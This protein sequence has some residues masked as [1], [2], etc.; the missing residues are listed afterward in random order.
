MLT[1]KLLFIL[2]PNAGV[3]HA[4][5]MIPE[6]LELFA[7]Q[8]YLSTVCCTRRRG[9][10]T[11]FARDH[12]AGMN[13]I[14]VSGGDGTLNEVVTGL[15]QGHHRIPV[16]YLPSGST[17]DFAAGLK[18]PGDL[19]KAARI[20]VA[21]KPQ[22]LDVGRFGDRYFCYTAGFGAFTGVAWSTPQNIKNVLGH[23]AYILEGIRSLGE[24]RPIHARVTADG[25]V[26]EDDWIFGAV[27]N[28]TSLGGVLKLDPDTVDMNDGMFE[29]VLIR[30]PSS[31]GE[32]AGI[33]EAVTT[34]NY[35]HPML[36]F[37]RASR[38]TFRTDTSLSWTLDGEYASGEPE[39]VIENIRDAVTV[40][41]PSEPS[42][43]YDIP[44]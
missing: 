20:A 23:A 38:L 25:L 17:N 26:C 31:A 42:F 8:G 1:K 6:L 35:S 40:M 3:R 34:R 43:L 10:A 21:G 41:T 13:L 4:R 16:G 7:D 2:N 30:N 36:H 27:C 33:L 12:A 19:L 18:L 29:T 24:I 32:L 11:D 39:T 5:R 44:E 14:V 9:D 15:L 22:K 37:I 28:S